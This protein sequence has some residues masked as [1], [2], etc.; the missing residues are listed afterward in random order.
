MI[1]FYDFLDNI[2]L[3][4]LSRLRIDGKCQRLGGGSF[5]I[6]EIPASVTKITEALLQMKRNRII[7]L[8]LHAFFTQES[9]KSISVWKP[10]D[11]LIVNMP[12]RFL[13]RQNTF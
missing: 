5:C 4:F 9:L 7:D 8:G 11:K 13:W 2:A 3:L 1:K 10:C 12:R 6:W